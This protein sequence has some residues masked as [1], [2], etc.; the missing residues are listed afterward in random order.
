A[1]MSL[2]KWALDLYEPQDDRGS[3]YAI[4]KYFVLRDAAENAPYPADN[5]PP[6]W[7]YGD[8]I[9]LNSDNDLVAGSVFRADWPFSRKFDAG[10]DPNNLS[11]GGSYNDL[12]IMRLAET[13]LLK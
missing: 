6:G 13:Y 5:L 7:S 8:T 4:R 11:G 1:R 10:P 2:T 12:I 9:H 3:E